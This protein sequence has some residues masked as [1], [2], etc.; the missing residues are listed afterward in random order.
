MI[1]YYKNTIIKLLTEIHE[2]TKNPFENPY[3]WRK[4][5]EKLIIQNINA[6]NKIRK[7]KEE[8]KDLNIKRKD[9]KTQLSKEESLVIKN[10]LKS[11]DFLIEEYRFLIKIYKDIG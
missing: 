7:I 2:N 5:Q 3:V 1:G 8:K 4:V 6:E 10:R 11:L 9:P